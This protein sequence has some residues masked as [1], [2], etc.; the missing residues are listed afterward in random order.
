MFDMD[1]ATFFAPYILKLRPPVTFQMQTL[2]TSLSAV[3][4]STVL[5]NPLAFHVF[6]GPQSN[7]S[8]S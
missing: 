5:K 8:L 3:D 1:S 6:P 4:P 2:F 7:S